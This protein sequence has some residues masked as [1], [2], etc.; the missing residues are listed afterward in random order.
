MPARYEEGG[1]DAL[2]D[3]SSKPHVIP[4]ATRVEVVG[5]VIYLRQT[6]HFGPH[7]IA[8]SIKRFHDIELLRTTET[9]DRDPM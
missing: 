6:Y 2:R 7:K 9:E 1:L 4:R 3:R 5:K 8:M